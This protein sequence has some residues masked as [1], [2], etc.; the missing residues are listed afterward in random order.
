M[1]Y[2]QQEVH[3]LQSALYPHAHQRRQ[4][5]V[6]RQF[7][8]QHYAEAI[9]LLEMAEA[10]CC[11]KF[12]FLRLFRQYYGRT[13]HQY[14]TALRLRQA[15]RRLLGGA[16]VAEACQAVGFDSVTSFTGLFRRT[17]GCPPRALAARR[18]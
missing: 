10:A 13:P 18:R 3:R 15:R 11:S 4:V 6:A 12:H 16:P 5:L 8:E 7:I 2:Y 17:Y 9:G 1:T 14:L